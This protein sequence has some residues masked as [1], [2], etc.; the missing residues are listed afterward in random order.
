MKKFIF[1]I[2]VSIFIIPFSV[3]AKVVKQEEINEDNILNYFYQI[4]DKSL[5]N[6]DNFYLFRSSS[7]GIYNYIFNYGSKCK[8]NSNNTSY[9][10]TIFS[11]SNFQYITLKSPDYN[12]SNITN[13]TSRSYSLS[14]YTLLSTSDNSITDS[15]VYFISLQDLVD[16]YNL[17]EYSSGSGSTD[18]PNVP[19]EP[20]EQEYNSFIHDISISII[21]SDIPDKYYFLYTISDFIILII[22]LFTLISPFIITYKL[23][24]V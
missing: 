23:L 24:G 2:L 8:L 7:N 5:I 11:S 3:N 22:L 9:T 17:P 19:I 10:C 6:K 14:T 1:F 4:S 16:Y 13:S 20:I 18:N 12:I 15:S 21:G